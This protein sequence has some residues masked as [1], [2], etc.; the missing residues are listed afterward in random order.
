[1]HCPVML[2]E[3]LNLLNVSEGG[4]YIDGTLGG[5]GHAEAIAGIAGRRGL[6]L[7]MDL[8]GEAIDRAKT[9]LARFG[10]AVRLAQGNF[11]AIADIARGNGIEKADGV[12]L[13]L[14]VSSEQLEDGARGFS[15]MRDGP[16]DM[17]MDA[18]G[19]KTALEIVAESDE[20]GIES[21]LRAGGET[22]L[23]RRIAR[24]IAAAARERPADGTAA[25]AATIARAAPRRGAAHAATVAFQAL[26]MAV[27]NE[28]GNLE[29]GLESA[30]E[31]LSPGG[32]LAA[33]SYHSIEDRVVKRC[34]L[35]HAGRWESLACGGARLE[36]QPPP[37]RIL[38][39]KALTPSE[40][41]LRDNRRARSGKLRCAE[42]LEETCPL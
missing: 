42:K 16:L 34:F 19:G 10:P 33:I 18:R 25:L 3:T 13:D 37:V 26:R 7:G 11:A 20:D 9:R 38:T 40:E 24:L 31:I 6:V 35:R 39:R 32:R 22:R 1:M 14:G 21:I 28:I 29:A 2:K 36:R 41:E 23:P 12:L 27:N 17:R 30:L 8:D 15:F 4:V 5:G